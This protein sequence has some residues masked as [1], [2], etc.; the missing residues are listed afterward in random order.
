MTWE[1]SKPYL[2]P[3]YSPWIGEKA[4]LRYF[5]KS[6][7]EIE[8]PIVGRSRGRQVPMRVLSPT[9][10][11]VLLAV[12]LFAI[13]DVAN[14]ASAGS[15]LSGTTWYPLRIGA[16]GWLTGVDI[17]SDGSVQVVRSDTY[18]AYIWNASSSQWTQLVTRNSM[19]AADIG[20]D[21]NAGVYE[22]RVAPNLPTRL[23]MAYRGY[24]YRSDNLGDQWTRTTFARVPMD[25]NDE[26]RMLGQKMAIDPVNPDVVYL[27]TPQ[28]GLFVTT[29]GGVT[30]RAVDA[31]PKSEPASNGQF[32]GITG[33]VFDATSGMNGG[34]TNTIYA[35]SYRHGVYGSINAGVSWTRL[36]GGPSS[37][38]HG[39]IATDGAYYVTG[40][41]GSSVWRYFSGAWTNIT[42]HKDSWSTV[43]TDPFDPARIVAIRG[44]GIF[45]ISHD[46]GATWSGLIWGP[47]GRDY[48]VAKDIPWLAWTNEKYM[49]EGDILFDPVTPNRL[50]FAEGIGVWHADLPNTQRAPASITFISQNVG[51]EQ[52]VA[53]QVIVPPGGKPVLASWDR[54]VFYVNNP[55]VFPSSHGPDNQFQIVMGWALDYASSKP[56]FIA[57]LFNWAGTE[58]S[59]YSADGGQSWTTFATYPPAAANGKIGGSIA[60]STPTN[61]VWA[62][63]DNSSPYYTL[64]GGMTWTPISIY[65]VPTNGETGW[66]FAHYLKRYIV[67]TDRVTAGTFFLYNYLKGLYRSSDGGANWTLIHSGQIAPFSG[68]NASLRSVPGQ[69]GHLFFTSGAQGNPGA[70]HPA[71]NAFKRS[72]NGGANWTSVPNVL[73]VRAFGFGKALTNY[74]TIFIAG[75]VKGIY[76]IWRSDDDAR[77]WVQIGDFPLDSLDNVVT[78]DGDK[79]V[80]GTVYVGFNGSG[81]AYG[82]GSSASTPATTAP[83]IVIKW[84]ADGTMFNGNGDLNIAV[85]AK[86]MNGIASIK[87]MAD[88][89]VLRQCVNTTLCAATWQGKSITQ[90]SHSISATAFNKA[91]IQGN[92]SITILSRS[93]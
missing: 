23:Y 37:V 11:S 8:L 87:I 59:G 42:P 74:P 39:K 86:D 81:Y 41:D 57:G 10:T 40:D 48:R 58:K 5:V 50:W 82:I 71:P 83:I 16:G 73:E 46:R 34:R 66:G 44:G 21:S 17:S 3:R 55:D 75:W 84:P 13:A 7:T 80:Y 12:F 49:A 67:A 56:S 88:S 51:I 36:A 90:G 45:D 72:T 77:S 15:N 18:G 6:V 24:V 63:S 52:L 69:A 53:N 91:G 1:N 47:D 93:R 70:P 85:F 2:S 19:P 26:Y 28:S 4:L 31:I 9:R 30:W 92:A 29:D 89:A 14:A 62:P 25:P 38:S 78:I 43:V 61:I 35:S 79:D 54:P 76:G 64:D 60:A 68:F 20:V 22:I 27:G 32:P 65:G 33:I